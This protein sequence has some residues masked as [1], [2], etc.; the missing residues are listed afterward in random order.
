MKRKSTLKRVLCYIEGYRQYLLASILLAVLTV[1]LTLYAPILT[2][3]RHRFYDWKGRGRF[4]S[5]PE[6]SDE[7]GRDYRSHLGVPVA[8][9]SL[10]QPHHL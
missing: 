10:Q 7:A 5:P 2:G 1:A 6:A 4:C 9:E 3:R 8:H